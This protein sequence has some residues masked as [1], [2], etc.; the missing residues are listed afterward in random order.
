MSPDEGRDK[1]FD[2]FN[3]EDDP[4]YMVH[5]LTP[6]NWVELAEFAARVL[7]L[8]QVVALPTDTVYGLAASARNRNG[9]WRLYEAKKRDKQ[10]PLAVCMADVKDV[11]MFMHTEHLPPRLLRKLL[12]GPVTLLL[13]QR[14]EYKGFEWCAPEVED[15]HGWDL[16][17][18]LAINLNQ[19]GSG[20]LGVR[21]PDSEFV[22]EVSRQLGDPLAL[23]SANPSGATECASVD[24]FRSLWVECAAIFDGGTLPSPV[25]PSTVIDLTEPGAFRITRAGWAVDDVVQLLRGRFG[26]EDRTEKP[27]GK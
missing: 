7:R 24:A 6:R 16:V 21:I 11:S 23:T 5:R 27:A 25:M 22:R 13:R 18:R 20:V 19:T 17:K 9:V 8:G 12:P 10:K 4:V 1:P 14:D 15:M 3:L 2:P 26:L